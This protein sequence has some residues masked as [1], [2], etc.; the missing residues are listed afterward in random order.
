VAAGVATLYQKTLNASGGV[1]ATATLTGTLVEGA[2]PGALEALTFPIPV[3]T[4]PSVYR[5][6]HG[7]HGP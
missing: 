4:D 5:A 7:H 3:N 2:G 6:G 1:T